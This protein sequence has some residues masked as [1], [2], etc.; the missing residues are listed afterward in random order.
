MLYSFDL[1]ITG[2]QRMSKSSV[3]YAIA[4]VSLKPFP[5][6][7]SCFLS[8]LFFTRACMAWRQYQGFVCVCMNNATASL[9]DILADKLTLGCSKCC[10]TNV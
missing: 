10:E 2:I 1:Y 9:Y 4:T 8:S 3:E 7:F 6:S 5:L